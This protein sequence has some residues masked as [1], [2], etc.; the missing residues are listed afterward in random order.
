[1]GVNPTS[2]AELLGC[3]VIKVGMK[4]QKKLPRG[5]VTGES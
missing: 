5:G 3:S 1:M 2:I 4:Q